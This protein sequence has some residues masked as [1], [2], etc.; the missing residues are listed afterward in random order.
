[1]ITKEEFREICDAV[2]GKK[3]V[4]EFVGVTERAVGHWLAGSRGIGRPEEA[5]IREL[6]RQHTEA[7]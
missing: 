7:A 4:A 2:G 1:M 6:H 5:R 3:V